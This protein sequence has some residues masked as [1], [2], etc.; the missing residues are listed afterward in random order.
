MHYQVY[1]IILIM[2]ILTSNC[3]FTTGGSPLP[4]QQLPWLF[5]LLLLYMGLQS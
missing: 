1:T 3:K 5:V 2:N 4:A